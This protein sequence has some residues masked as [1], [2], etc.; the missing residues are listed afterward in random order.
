MHIIHL[1]YIADRMVADNIQL[2]QRLLS[3]E[4]KSLG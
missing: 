3:H 2:S 4:E 1:G